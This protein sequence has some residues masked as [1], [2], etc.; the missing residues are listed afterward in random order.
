[1]FKYSNIQKRRIS[2]LRRDFPCLFFGFYL[3]LGEVLGFVLPLPIALGVGGLSFL[4]FCSGRKLGYLILPVGILLT[5]RT[6]EV[7]LPLN[8]EVIVKAEVNEVPRRP[9]PELMMLSLKLQ[10]LR[11]VKSKKDNE[12]NGEKIY[13]RAINLPWRNTSKIEVGD[14][15]S[16]RIMLFPLKS[17]AAEYLKRH[18]YI[19]QC[20]VI[21]VALLKN[22]KPAP[23]YSLKKKL[24]SNVRAVLGDNERSAIFLAS[25]LGFRDVISSRLENGYRKTGLS[26]LLVLSGYQITLMFYFL[27]CI[28]GIPIRLFPPSYKWLFLR[29]ITAF[30]ALVGSLLFI[31]LAGIEGSSLRAGIAALMTFLTKTFERSS[32]MFHSVTVAF[33]LMSILWPGSFMEPGL[34][35]TFAALLGINTAAFLG[36]MDRTVTLYLRVCFYASLF[37]APFV[38]YWFDYL[39]L[40]GVAANPVL[41]PIVS[42]VGCKVGFIAIALNFWK[43]D[44]DGYLLQLASYLIEQCSEVIMFLAELPYGGFEVD[45]IHKMVFLFLLSYIVFRL[46]HKAYIVYLEKEGLK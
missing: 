44:S 46:M 39:S 45:G 25:S 8:R 2:A 11:Q 10:K 32:S 23:F 1:M 41:A 9:K 12:L 34:Q 24:A 20:K 43:V 21:Y 37:T 29:H 7:E 17:K 33:L 36:N 28:F 42:V 3:A 5:L 4:M 6:V 31:A 16:A 13:C 18:G 35:L 26:H 40:I 22:G 14:Y 38:L 15:I 19:A 30:L 27:Y